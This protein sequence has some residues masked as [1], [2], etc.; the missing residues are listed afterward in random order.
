MS[1]SQSR[2]V[3]SIR[4]PN[5]VS[6]KEA[7]EAIL[8][9]RKTSP[10]ALFEGSVKEAVEECRMARVRELQGLLRGPDGLWK[11]SA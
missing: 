5:G 6:R 1:A 9:A 10:V 11:K 7:V 3:V 4:L 2:L 8:E